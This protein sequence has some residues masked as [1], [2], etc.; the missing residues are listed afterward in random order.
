MTLISIFYNL[1]IELKWF[2]FTLYHWTDDN[3]FIFPQMIAHEVQIELMRRKEGPTSDEPISQSHPIE[4]LQPGQPIEQVSQL[5]KIFENPCREL[6]IHG[7][8]I[9][10]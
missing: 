1:L 10:F 7:N 9:G 8:R 6:F 2:I 4:K 3:N 5:F